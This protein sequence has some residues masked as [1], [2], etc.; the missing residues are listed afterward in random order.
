MNQE[1]PPK[2]VKCTTIHGCNNVQIVMC[3]ITFMWLSI[4]LVANLT[5]WHYAL[6]IEVAKEVVSRGYYGLPRESF[7]DKPTHML[8]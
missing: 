1:G 6:Y 7:L 4:P 5:I 2:F 3:R 8:C